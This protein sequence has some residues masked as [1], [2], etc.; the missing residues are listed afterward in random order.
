VP[1]IIKFRIH[2]RSQELATP[3]SDDAKRS[4]EILF[5]KRLDIREIWM[6]DILP[7]VEQETR[8]KCDKITQDSDTVPSLR[9][10]T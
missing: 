7:V 9:I 5:W 10:T 6:S 2:H 8:K 1:A 3:K 4:A